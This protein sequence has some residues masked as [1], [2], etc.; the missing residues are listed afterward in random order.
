[1]RAIMTYVQQ[2]KWKF[3]ATV[4]LMG[5]LFFAF[6]TF[7]S[8]SNETPELRHRKLLST[9]GHLLESEHYSPRKIDD[10]K[11]IYLHKKILIH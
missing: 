11:R 10:Q 9:I 4:V 6:N 1:M 3:L 2:N 7:K 8:S 5:G